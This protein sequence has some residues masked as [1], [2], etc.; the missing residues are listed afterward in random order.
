MS[1]GRRIVASTFASFAF[2]LALLSA[3]DANASRSLS[4]DLTSF[5]VAGT[6]TITNGGTILSGDCSTQLDI[7]LSTNPIPKVAGNTFSSYRSGFV[8]DC[9]GPLIPRTNNTGAI[10][11][12]TFKYSSFTG[13]LP[14][15][16]SIAI[17]STDFSASVNTIVG[18]CLYRATPADPL[19]GIRITADGR[20]PNLVTG[21]TLATDTIARFSG[22]FLCPTTA[23]FSGTLAIIRPAPTLTLV[24]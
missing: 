20:A 13:P 15:V 22:P 17:A 24:N 2:A 18:N 14:Q 10:L 6:V 8:R 9:V 3:T 11:G 4:S 16:T 21:M 23:A 12:A 5:S 7:S 19:N 1:D